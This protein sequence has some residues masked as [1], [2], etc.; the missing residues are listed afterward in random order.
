MIAADIP[1]SVRRWAD[2]PVIVERGEV[3]VERGAW[4]NFC[5]A[6]E[7]ANPLYWDERVAVDISNGLIAPPAM[8][9][10]WSKPHP[11]SAR[12]TE[13]PP[14][15]LELH[16]MLKD[17]LRL[18]LGI[19]RDTELIFLEPLRGGEKVT[20]EQYLREV[21]AERT[22]HLGTGR[23]WMIEVIYRR[24]DGIEVGIERIRCFGYRTA[25]K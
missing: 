3:P 15:P 25:D 1:E 21:S 4:E 13:Q 22:T 7:D 16:F 18:P 23:N 14:R 17:E 6:V 24:D 10:C 19:V 9:S 5:S 8:L 20:G 2:R 12:H 11:W